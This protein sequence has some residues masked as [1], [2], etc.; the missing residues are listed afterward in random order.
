LVRDP[1]AGWCGRRG[2]ARFL[3]IPITILSNSIIRNTGENS[4]AVNYI[5]GDNKNISNNTI[6]NNTATGTAPTYTVYMGSFPLLN[7]NNIFANSAMYELWNNNMQGLKD[8]DAKNNWWGVSLQSEIEGRIYHFIDDSVKAIADYIPWDTATRTD[9]PLSPPSGLAVTVGTGQIVLTWTANPEPDVAGYKIYWDTDPGRPYA[10]SA[11]AGNVIN[12]AISGLSAG[13]YYF[14]VTAYDADYN[15]ANDEPDTIVNE[16][17]T[18]GNESWY[19]EESCNDGVSAISAKLNYYRDAD[20]DTFGDPDE[21][22]QNCTPPQGYVTDNTDCN[23]S[24]ALEFPGQTWYKDE[25]NDG[26]SDGTIEVSCKRPSI[27][28]KALPNLTAVTGD[29]KDADKSVNPGAVEGP[30]GEIT[31]LD[32]KD[33]DCDSLPDYTD[34]DCISAGLDLFV[35][36]VSNPPA[37]SRRG[38]DFTVSY[39]VIN[40]GEIKTGRSR[41]LFYLS[42]DT[43]KND[44]D[45]PLKNKGLVPKL[46][47]GKRLI[48]KNRVIISKGTEPGYYYVI[49][50][51]D[52]I[53]R[54]VE[55]NEGNNCSASKNTLL[56]K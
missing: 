25:D 48:L 33:N 38:S 35:I 2:T 43:V 15:S 18:N 32:G 55:S 20:K 37:S 10:N 24:N 5:A 3:P 9:A 50:C 14:T 4:P 13:T 19:A 51:A 44:N 54:I 6:A 45:I 17:Q 56:V 30:S 26:Y 46:N 47:S 41:T 23:D 40:Q 39:I 27:K 21:T 11:D 31:C 16:N 29:C 53:N 8:L 42:T 49:A 1:Y 22:L 52:S 28:Y 7:Y 34:P 36:S 12:Y